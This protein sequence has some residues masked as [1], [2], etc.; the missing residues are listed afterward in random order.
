MLKTTVGW[1]LM[2]RVRNRDK[3]E[4]ELRRAEELLGEELR[5]RNCEPYWKIPE[6]WRCQADTDFEIPSEAEQITACLLRA[7]RLAIGWY[8]LG[9]YF[10][11][12]GTLESFNGIFDRHQGK[13]AKI[14]S[15]EWAQFQVFGSAYG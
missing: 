2:F 9:P 10:R 12:D 13:G 1:T 14:Q 7:N 8:V 4:K 3:A 15:L 11:P 5:L 6:L